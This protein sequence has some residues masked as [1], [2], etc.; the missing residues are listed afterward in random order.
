MENNENVVAENIE[1]ARPVKKKSKVGAVFFGLWVILVYVAVVSVP[2]L[3]VMLPLI[4]DSLMIAQGDSVQFMELFFRKMAEN[5]ASLTLA[6]AAGTSIAVIL[7]VLWYYFG[8]YRKNQKLGTSENVL[9]KLKNANSILFLVCGTIASFACAAA[10]QMALSVIMPNVSAAFDSTM[11]SVLSGVTALGFVM[12]LVLAPIGEEVAMRGLMIN[13]AKKSFGLVGC[14]ILSGILFGVFHLNPIQG[15]YAIPIG[16]FFGFV[17]YKYNSVVP[18]IFAHSLNNLIA[19]FSG[20]LGFG[21]WYVSAG[22]LVVFAV[23]MVVF[24]KKVEFLSAKKVTEEAEET[25]ETEET[26]STEA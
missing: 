18:C 8:A 1:T 4:A 9:P 16:A 24:G 6:T 3:L 23:L 12:T 22:V 21:R 10:I 14:V 26:V 5:S 11:N 13:R 15:L 7:V 19:A 17:A 20:V 2:Q 25:E